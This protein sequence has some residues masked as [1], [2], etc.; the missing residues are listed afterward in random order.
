MPSIN[1][2]LKFAAVASNV[3]SLAIAPAARFISSSRSTSLLRIVSTSSAATF[4]ASACFAVFFISF[5]FRV[6][7]CVCVACFRFVVFVFGLRRSLSTMYILTTLKIKSIVKYNFFKKNFKK[8][9]S[10]RKNKAQNVKK[11]FL[12]AQKRPI[13]D[14]K[15]PPRLVL[16]NNKRGKAKS[17]YP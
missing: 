13:F 3:S 5:A 7:L 14:Q 8:D 16:Q 12:L 9:V 11:F 15:S 10:P 6:S 2:R 4:N 1:C 17:R